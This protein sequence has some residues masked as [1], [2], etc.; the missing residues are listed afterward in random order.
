MTGASPV[1]GLDEEGEGEDGL[2]DEGCTGTTSAK[3]VATLRANLVDIPLPSLT[4]STA[5]HRQTYKSIYQLY[6]IMSSTDCHHAS[7]H[8]HTHH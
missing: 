3:A 1:A 6:S 4:P 2:E 5:T 8:Y 7:P